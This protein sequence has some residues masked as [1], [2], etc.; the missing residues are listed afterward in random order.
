M[1]NI[2]LCF[3]VGATTTKFVYINKD[4]LEIIH[5]GVFVTK[6]SGND[7]K[8]EYLVKKVLHE[9]DECLKKHQVI[10]IGIATCGGVDIRTQKITH[11]NYSMKD[12]LG[13]DWKSLVSDRYKIKTIVINDVKA[14]GICEFKDVNSSSGIMITLGSGIGASFFIN[15]KLHLGSRYLCGEIGQMLW[16]FN[17]NITTDEACSSVI[18]TN[19]IKKIL[20]DDDFKLTDDDKVASN[21]KALEIKLEWMKNIAYILQVLDYFFDPE[22]FIIGG[23]VS[24]HKEII[25]DVLKHLPSNFKHVQLA[26][27]ANDAAFYGLVILLNT[28]Y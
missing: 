4:T 8:S 25:Y 19:K 16:P 22:I 28:S 7:F 6:E 26:R 15:G 18:A 24:K 17:H 3:D 20:N 11:V 10:G 1:E 5:R 2:Y 12:Y 21:P 23:G 14:A 27:N 13:T 9:I